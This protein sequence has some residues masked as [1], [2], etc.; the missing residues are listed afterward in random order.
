[1]AMKH[2]LVRGASRCSWCR[3]PAVWSPRDWTGSGSSHHQVSSALYRWKA[4]PASCSGSCSHGI[5]DARSC[6]PIPNNSNV[7]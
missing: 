4:W 2:K 1:M 6:H 5:A 7:R 3:T